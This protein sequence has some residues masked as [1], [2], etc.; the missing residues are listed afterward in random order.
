MKKTWMNAE[1]ADL[2]INGTEYSPNGGKVQDGQ[3]VSNDGKY[4]I[5]T[6]GPS[7]QNEGEPGVEVRP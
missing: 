3:Y 1:L 5:N 6:W 4:E 2:S 7:G